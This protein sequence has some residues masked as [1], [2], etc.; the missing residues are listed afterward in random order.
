MSW[1]ECQR[2][3]CKYT[4]IC[5]ETTKIFELWEEL[6]EYNKMPYLICPKCFNQMKW[7]YEN[8]FK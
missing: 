3:G 1:I 5:L 7:V 6:E 8:E 2:N 4:I